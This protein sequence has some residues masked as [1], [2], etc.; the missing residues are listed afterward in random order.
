[1]PISYKS[2]F[3]SPG[4]ATA[5]ADLGGYLRFE[6]GLDPRVREL[7]VLVVN[8]ETGCEFG[9]VHHALLADRMGVPSSVIG[10]LHARRTPTGLSEAEQLGV[11]AAQQTLREGAA[12][13]ETVAELV[14]VFGRNQATDLVIAIGYYTMLAQYFRTIDLEATEEGMAHLGAGPDVVRVSANVDRDH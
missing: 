6:S 9:W 11:R 14:R 7:A 10:D 4:A 1:V 8:A 2:M 13:A 3:N 5:I 12:G